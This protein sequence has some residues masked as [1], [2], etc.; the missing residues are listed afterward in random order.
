MAEKDFRVR[1]GLVVDG[2]G[3]ATS[4]AVTTGNVVVTAG[5]LGLT[6]GI[7]LSTDTGTSPNTSKITSQPTNGNI[8][9]EPNGTGDVVLVTDNLDVSG[10]S[11]KIS[12]KDN[13]AD[14][15]DITESTNSYMKFITSNSAELIA[16]G[17]DL[18]F[19]KTSNHKISIAPTSGT[20]QTGRD[21]IFEAGTSTG[22]VLGGEMVFKVGGGGGSSGTTATTL[23]TALTLTGAGVA[24]IPTVDIGGGALDNTII[25]ATAQNTAKVTTLETT[26]HAR[27]NGSAREANTLLQV[28]GD[29]VASGGNLGGGGNAASADT[30]K[31]AEVRI[32]TNIA[33]DDLAGQHVEEMGGVYIIENA[34]NAPLTG[35]GSIYTIGDSGTGDAWGAGRQSETGMYAIGYI[36]KDYDNIADSNENPMRTGQQRLLL[37]KNGNLTLP[38]SDSTLSFVSNGNTTSFKGHAS[39]ADN[40]TYQFPPDHPASSGQVLSSTDAGVMSWIAAGGTPAITA[41]NNATENELLTVG[42]TTTEVDAEPNLLYDGNKLVMNFDTSA[43]SAVAQTIL[44]IDVDKSGITA[45]S[46]TTS[47]VGMDVDLN[48]AATNNNGSTVTMTGMDMDVVAAN[49]TGTYTNIGLDIN[50]TGADDNYAAIFRAGNVGIGTATPA[51]PLQLESSSSTGP[52]LN[53]RNTHTDN[54]GGELRFWQADT[55]NGANG[56]VL[57]TMSFYGNDGGGA[58][59]VFANII[60]KTSDVTAGAEEGKLEFQVATAGSSGSMETILTIDGG[61]AAASSTITSTGDF[62]VAGDTTVVGLTASG[63][64]T[65]VDI[66]ST[67]DIL[68]GDDIQMT[69]GGRIRPV[70]VSGDNGAGNALGI[71]AGT[72]KGTGAGGRIDF[73]TKSA[74]GG[75]AGSNHS[76]TNSI[77]MKDGKLGIGTITPSQALNV[78]KDTDAEFIAID[79]MNA[80]N[81][82]NTDGYVSMLFNLAT[83]GDGTVDAGKIAVRKNTSFTSTASTQNSNMEFYTSLNGN[84]TKRFEVL[85]ESAKVT[86][87]LEVTGDLNITGDI[88]ST[89][90]TDLDVVDKT[91]TV[92]SGATN[93]D[94]SNASGLAFGASGA[95]LQYLHSGTKIVINKPLDVTGNLNVTGTLTGDTSLTVDAVTVDSA[96]LNYLADVTAGTVTASKAVVV[97][98]SKDIGT[99]RAISTEYAKLTSTHVASGQIAAAATATVATI[100]ST[101]HRGAEIL[102]TV[103]NTTDNTTDLFKTVVMWDGHDSTLDNASAACHYTNYAVLSSGDVASGD[104]SAVKSGANILV[105]FTATG[106]SNAGDDT[107]I[108]RSQQT[109]LAI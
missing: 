33:N 105:K 90:V 81:S 58:D 54:N 66:I 71:K 36:A 99:F 56:D 84:L 106:G 6:N 80:S 43:T 109:L 22:N 72:G 98:G 53:I 51:F 3:S 34:E 96:E 62:D 60:A 59:Q 30:N 65:G 89:S 42:S 8:H 92:A 95:T 19:E 97:D 46:T 20:D 2:T 64:I 77:S 75:S 61:A 28:N 102:T 93:S 29:F 101:T 39:A 82:A 47:L 108:I 48:D 40:I 23:T 107:Y 4:V 87:D 38:V 76:M 49:P 12:I 9:I 100:V 68:P 25:G 35:Q 52:V 67:D 41:L 7:L 32:H 14:A 27:I 73:Y 18:Q 69:S 78:Y 50:V 103:Y 10:D 94:E 86:G 44:H 79:V 45:N 83:T 55:G 74:D 63:N 21:L 17:K 88:N 85:S 26:S 57:G 11:M 1:K 15:L 70:D 5:T 91:I 104:I 37:N 13:V 31:Y 16:L 24:V